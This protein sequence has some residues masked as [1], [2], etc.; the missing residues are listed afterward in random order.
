MSGSGLCYA[1]DPNKGAQVYA[2]HCASCHGLSGISVMMGA[3]SFAKNE[4]LMSPDSALL[5]SI[6]GGKAAM[7]AYRGVLN[8]QDILDVIAYLRTMN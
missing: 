8:D 4:G 5:I 3:P 2:T 1:A 7:P 6:R